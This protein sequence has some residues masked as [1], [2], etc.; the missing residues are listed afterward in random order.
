MLHIKHKVTKQEKVPL[1]P[2][3]HTI[4]LKHKLGPTS[5]EH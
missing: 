2:G 1:A 5:Q 3:G 4:H